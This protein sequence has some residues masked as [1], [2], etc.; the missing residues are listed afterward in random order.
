MSILLL[1]I[2]VPIVAPTAFM[3]VPSHASTNNTIILQSYAVETGYPYYKITT[4]NINISA[5]SASNVTVAVDGVPT[6]GLLDINLSGITISSGSVEL[7]T[8]S[9]GLASIGTGDTA[10]VTLPTGYITSIQHGSTA[11]PLVHFYNYTASNGVTYAL[12]NDSII[13]PSPGNVGGGSYYIK[14][15]F[16]SS[17]PVAVSTAKL[18]ILPSI[19]ISP[20]S[21][22]AGTPI[23]VTGTGFTSSSSANVTYSYKYDSA[24]KLTT[25]TKTGIATNNTGGFMYTF[26]APEMAL[27]DTGASF[28][29]GTVSVV[30]NDTTTLKATGTQTFTEN[31]RQLITF[32]PTTTSGTS[33]NLVNSALNYND[34]TTN[35]LAPVYIKEPVNIIGNYFDPSSALT[36]TYNGISLGTATTNSTG[37]FNVTFTI[38]IVAGGKYYLNITD[39]LA[40]IGLYTATT[41]TLVVTPTSVQPS[42]SIAINGYGFPSSDSVS[43]IWVHVVNNPAGKASIQSISNTS[44]SS[45]GEFTASFTIPLLTPGGT[46][47]VGANLT[48]TSFAYTNT[49]TFTNITIVPMMEISPST[50]AVGTT[51]NATGYGLNAGTGTSSF[52][53]GKTTL[54]LGH[55]VGD[56]LVAYDNVPV[57]GSSVGATPSYNGTLSVLLSAVGTPMIHEVQLVNATVAPYVLVA[58]SPLNVTGTINGVTSQVSGV[59]AALASIESSLMSITSSLTSLSSAVS[60]ISSGIT[61]IESSL[62]SITSTLSSISGTLTSMGSTLTSIQTAVSGLN[63]SN[64]ASTLSNVMTYLLVVAVLAIIIIVLEIVLLVRKK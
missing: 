10:Y 23:T 44:I 49:Y 52:N 22:G 5:L 63:T 45:N 27:N 37:Y 13:G 2:I 15:F 33:N 7:Y 21:G 48:G 8:S 56:Y 39:P 58:S 61:N 34:T 38:P 14:A 18:V 28:H 46:A 64:L 51:V 3:A 24:S 41:E 6:V 9:S 35:L 47:S 42:G 17:A 40:T 20:A 11:G 25:V 30:G 59:S 31:S 62:S 16:G 57:F 4:A 12:G 54:S 26:N 19:S 32:A 1:G 50:G 53:S 43:V 60:N 29:T 55:A 36:F